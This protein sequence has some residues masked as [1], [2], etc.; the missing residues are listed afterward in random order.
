MVVMW[1]KCIECDTTAYIFLI[2]SFQFFFLYLYSG[3]SEPHNNKHMDNKKNKAPLK[4]NLI[5]LRGVP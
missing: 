3:P 1:V 2:C 4:K 5:L